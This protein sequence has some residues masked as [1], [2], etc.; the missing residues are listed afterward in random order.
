MPKTS[1]ASLRS[2]SLSILPYQS[3][4]PDLQFPE[5][6]NSMLELVDCL[7]VV[8]KLMK[9]HGQKEKCFRVV[10]VNPFKGLDGFLGCANT[11][12]QLASN[13]W[14]LESGLS[15]YRLPEY[16]ARR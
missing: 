1:A 7:V 12:F 5:Q 16:N 2:T 11:E 10:L 13:G 4:S 14:T 6:L 8:S 3:S 15:L 9:G